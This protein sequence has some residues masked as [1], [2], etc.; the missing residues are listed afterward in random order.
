MVSR[1]AFVESVLAVRGLRGAGVGIEWMNIAEVSALVRGKKT[2]PVELTR[3]CLERIEKLNGRLNAFLTITADRAL[4]DA[5]TLEAEA[6]GGKWRG[7]L[8]GIPIGL[9]DL[10]DTA[11]VRTTAASRQWTDRVPSKDAEVVRRL[12]AAGA[13]V[14][15]KTNM[16]EF[17]YNFTG[18]T[19]FFGT[20]RNP[21]DLRR[22]PGGSSGGSAVAV[23]A[24]MCFAALGSDTGGS[25]RLPAALCG[26]T[27]LKPTYGLVSTDGVA[28]LAWSLDHVGPMC[29][30]ARDA[31]I[32]LEA[33]SGKALREAA[34][35]VATLRLGVPLT[36]FY[37]GIDPEVEK[38]VADATRLL[39]GMTRGAE[40][41]V[42]PAL[43]PFP[44]M[45]ELPDT[46]SRI[47]SA[48]AYAFHQDMLRAHPDRYDA[49]TRKSIEAGAAITTADYI[50]ARR[51]MDRLREQAHRWF[52]GADLL[53]TP[54]APGAAFEF[55]VRRL[56]FLRNTAPWN[57]L[58]L[59]SISIPC[60]FTAGGLPIGFQITGAAGR[61]DAVLSLAVAYQK[62]TD[63]HRRQ[64][65]ET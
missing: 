23:A 21:W 14:L 57:L 35:N 10:Y 30:T 15:G 26:I 27:G 12:K 39:S 40:A 8:H 50:L 51:E 63:W 22:S 43:P 4:A 33:L 52:A 28:P 61:D 48:E 37:D 49:G 36:V 59:P 6:R 20:S 41:V 60:G 17:A 13:I 55:G 9:K 62:T 44:A 45:P 64:P 5:K 29:R 42:L 19:S 65:P 53:I 24:G 2:S 38:A 56:A 47:I 18:E 3:L 25:I 1:R 11:G 32:M 31:A 16:D 34:V 58:G 46:Y 54:T 7:L